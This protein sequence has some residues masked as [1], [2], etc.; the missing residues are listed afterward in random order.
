MLGTSLKILSCF[1]PE[2]DHSAPYIVF[3]GEEE[4]TRARKGVDMHS[5]TRANEYRICNYDDCSERAIDIS[6]CSLHHYSEC[7]VK[8]EYR[9]N[10]VTRHIPT[11]LMR[12]ECCR[13]IVQ[14]EKNRAGSLYLDG[15][16]EARDGSQ[17][18]LIQRQPEITQRIQILYHPFLPSSLLIL[19]LTPSC[20]H[21]LHYHS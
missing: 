10:F 15:L 16:D 9:L 21:Y 12:L 17:L 13:S 19:F 6:D 14:K 8:Y 18:W 3:S 20:S 2:A 5:V 4:M 11:D 1:R 7:K